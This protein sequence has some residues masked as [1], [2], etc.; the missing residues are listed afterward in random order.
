MT[1][2]ADIITV[3]NKLNAKQKLSIKDMLPLEDYHISGAER[4]NTKYGEVI[5]L[6]LVTSILYL[7]KRFNS[8][9]SEDIQQLSTGAYLITKIPFNNNDKDSYHC[10]LEIKPVPP[11]R[12]YYPFNTFK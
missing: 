4:M 6:E 5:V 9:S 7:P 1:T 8:L 12:D 2:N 10:R 3:F 11:M